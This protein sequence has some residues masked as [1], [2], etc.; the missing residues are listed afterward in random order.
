MST[1]KS[2]HQISD[3]YKKEYIKL[4]NIINFDKEYLYYIDNMY[5]NFY[6]LNHKEKFH[7]IDIEFNNHL[8]IKLRFKLND[9][10]ILYYII[11]IINDIY[12]IKFHG[13]EQLLY[14][15]LIQ[16]TAIFNDIKNV[17]EENLEKILMQT[18]LIQLVNL[19]YINIYS[20]IHKYFSSVS[21]LTLDEFEREMKLKYIALLWW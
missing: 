6:R 20:T 16:A 10:P 19:N 21:N 2:Y 1:F 9:K 14:E 13:D 18:N 3:F 8:E 5:E 11:E 15:E 7:S 17:V 12:Q 4:N